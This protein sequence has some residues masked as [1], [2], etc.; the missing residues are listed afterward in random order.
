MATTEENSTTDKLRKR[1]DRL[2]KILLDEVPEANSKKVE[3]VTKL[4]EVR[5]L[6][7]DNGK[8]SASVSS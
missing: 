7:D 2:V 6:L 5:E 8:R 4:L 3:I 1:L